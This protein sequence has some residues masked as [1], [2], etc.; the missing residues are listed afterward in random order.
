MRKLLSILI[1]LCSCSVMTAQ[2]SIAIDTTLVKNM[3]ENRILNEK[4]DDIEPPKEK[5]NFFWH[6]TK[7][8]RTI[9]NAFD[10]IDT[11]YIERQKYNWAAMFQTTTT[12][13]HYTLKSSTG[14]KITLA[15]NLTT[16]VGPYFGWRWIFAGYT[17][18]FL[19]DIDYK[20]NKMEYQ[21]AFY[22]SMLSLDLIWRNTGNN[23]HVKNIY[24][25]DDYDTSNAIG[26]KF[27]GLS[28]EIIGANLTYIFN[29]RRF[30]YPAAYQ[31]S[32][33]QLRS[34]GSALIGLGYTQHKL[35][36][37]PDALVD[38]VSDARISTA[39]IDS[40]FLF[41]NIDYRD[42]ALSGGYSYNWVLP[43]NFVVNAS[44]S[45]ALS[46][47]SA[48]GSIIDDI[49]STKEVFSFDR[50][51]FDTILRTAI[52]WN[53]SKWFAGASYVRHSYNYAR[54]SFS[55]SN[56]FGQLNIYGG[57]NFGK[58]KRN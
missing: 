44:L 7:P 48:N 14:Q 38:V 22:T 43:H 23:Y 53:T 26:A 31:Q 4:A 32:T 51:N 37:D 46:Y 16:K 34:A 47:K 33:R 20:R 36:I 28:S 54:K 27:T 13:E 39:A 15:P 24:L 45:A 58:R 6:V 11:T 29:H 18:D 40:S 2:D 50:F 57:V 12:H 17:L 5:H 10:D 35:T 8:V 9:L 3:A 21:F 49:L 55:T 30:S 42:L 19:T 1:C 56:A 41:K 52:V 25:G